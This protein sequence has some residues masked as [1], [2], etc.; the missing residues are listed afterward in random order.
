[1]FLSERRGR[2]IPFGGA[3]FARRVC[4]VDGLACEALPAMD[5]GEEEMEMEM[6]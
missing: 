4:G 5:K 3:L 1:V 2:H 6:G